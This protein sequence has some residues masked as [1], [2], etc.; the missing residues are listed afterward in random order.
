MMHNQIFKANLK[1][2]VVV[3]ILVQA[4]SCSQQK[5]KEAESNQPKSVNRFSKRFV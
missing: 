4:Q 5:E 3:V 1:V 2:L